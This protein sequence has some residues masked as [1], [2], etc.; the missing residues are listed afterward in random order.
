L[1]RRARAGIY[2]VKPRAK[3]LVDR[4]IAKGGIVAH[5]QR[6]TQGGA[7][8]RRNNRAIFYLRGT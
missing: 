7:P 2:Q 1:A 3:E 6:V 8:Q 5:A 4:F